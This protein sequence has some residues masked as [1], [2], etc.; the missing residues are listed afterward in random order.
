MSLGET[1]RSGR[2][3]RRRQRERGKGE[4]LAREVVCW[5]GNTKREEPDR[6]E[7]LGED[8]A[9]NLRFIFQSGPLFCQAPPF[10]LPACPLTFMARSAKLRR[11]RRVVV[12]VL[13]I[14]VLA[15]AATV[16]VVVGSKLARIYKVLA[17]VC[18]RELLFL[19]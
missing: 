6:A 14:V 19:P 18:H 1:D 17:L 13:V 5:A 8:V 16:V 12:V 3:R 11:G 10:S 9:G 7:M 15:P 2:R 4:G